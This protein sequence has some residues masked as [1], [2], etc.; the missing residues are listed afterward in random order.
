MTKI[1]RLMLILICGYINRWKGNQMQNC[2]LVHRK[3]NPRNYFCLQR[4]KFL[5]CDRLEHP[6]SIILGF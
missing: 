6:K 2:F 1:V 5:F 3:K 4:Y